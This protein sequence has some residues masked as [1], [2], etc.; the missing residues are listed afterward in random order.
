MVLRSG[1]L[2]EV[3]ADTLSGASA[4]AALLRHPDEGPWD[5][6]FTA[7]EPAAMV[8]SPVASAADADDD[9][10]DVDVDDGVDVDVDVD[11]DPPFQS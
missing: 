5:F 10:V 2:L 1:R 9:G 6:T 3:V 4:I 7:G 8:T 11:V